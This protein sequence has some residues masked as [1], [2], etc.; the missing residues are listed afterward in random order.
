S[1]AVGRLRPAF[2]LRK[3]CI[4]CVAKAATPLRLDDAGNGISRF[5]ADTD[6]TW[7]A[8]VEPQSETRWGTVM[9]TFNGN[10]LANVIVGSPFNDPLHRLRRHD[11]LDYRLGGRTHARHNHH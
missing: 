8:S 5:V 6:R 11:I 10:N 7:P 1:I 2:P 3:L 9:P 4:R